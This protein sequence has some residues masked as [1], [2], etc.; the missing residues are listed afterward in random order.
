MVRWERL[1]CSIGG[2]GGEGKRVSNT[3]RRVDQDD[4]ESGKGLRNGSVRSST[5]LVFARVAVLR[6]AL[7]NL[8]RSAVGEGGGTYLWAYNLVPTST[9]LLVD[10]ASY[11]GAR[12][13]QRCIFGATQGL[14]DRTA[15]IEARPARKR[16]G[17]L[18]AG[19]TTG[20]ECR[21][22][23]SSSWPPK[24]PAGRCLAC[25]TARALGMLRSCPR[26][27]RLRPAAAAAAAAARLDQPVSGCCWTVEG[28]GWRR[29]WWWLWSGRTPQVPPS[30]H[31]ADPP[32]PWRRTYP[33]RRS[34][35]LPSSQFL[36]MRSVAQQQQQPGRAP[37]SNG[38]V[39]GTKCLGEGRTG[40][41]GPLVTKARNRR[42]ALGGTWEH[43]SDTELR[44][45]GPASPSSTADGDTPASLAITSCSSQQ[46]WTWGMMGLRRVAWMPSQ[47]K[48]DVAVA[49]AGWL[50]GGPVRPPPGPG[51][52]G[53][54]FFS[55]TSRRS[56]MEGGPIVKASC[57]CV[58]V[59]QC[60]HVVCVCVCR[61][62]GHLHDPSTP[63]LAPPT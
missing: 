17:E 51:N 20:G 26:P 11:H 59:C 22:R 63:V 44:P 33:W 10:A 1:G 13:R 43:L 12:T 27:H 32:S 45:R 15:V 7:E 36:R 38:R 39:Q 30:T 18:V 49:V 46:A 6:R 48:P 47:C 61:A 60:A 54:G 25:P 57:V 3:T 21:P 41:H 5:C 19:G 53:I 14:R 34:P 29:R 42:S 8:D 56:T 35:Q 9:T 28:W 4:P 58:C 16:R 50:A 2:M 37:S 31:L 52:S 23:R 24:F 40:P 55:S 62:Q